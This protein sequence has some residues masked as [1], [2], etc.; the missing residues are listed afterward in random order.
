MNYGV[1]RG[2]GNSELEPYTVKVEI[3]LVDSAKPALYQ[4]CTI[5]VRG[6]NGAG[7]THE[8][9]RLSKPRHSG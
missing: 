7:S 9:I 6:Q 4:P 5:T 1:G 2:M 3:R 8:Y